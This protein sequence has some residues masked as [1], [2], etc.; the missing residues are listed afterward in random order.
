M[1]TNTSTVVE[2]KNDLPEKV[3]EYIKQIEALKEKYKGLV[4]TDVNDKEQLKLIKAGRIEFKNARVGVEKYCKGVRD[5]ANAFSKTVIQKEKEIVA[6][7]QPEEERLEAEE[8]KY[9]AEQQR[10]AEIK[11]KAEEELFNGRIKELYNLGFTVSEKGYGLYG[12][13]ITPTEI[14][15]MEP[16]AWQKVMDGEVKAA[17]ELDQADKARIARE[18]QERK[19]ADEKQ[20]Q[21]E[22]AK[23]KE[24]A[25]RLEKQRLEQ[26]EERKRLEAERDEQARKSNE[27]IQ[28]ERELQRLEQERLDAEKRKEEAIALEKQQEQLK[29]QAI[30]EER[31]R[32]EKEAKN[33]EAAEAL[34]REQE[35][36]KEER[37]PDKKKLIEFANSIAVLE[38]PEVKQPMMKT[39]ATGIKV[40][41]KELSDLIKKEVG[42]L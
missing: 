28:K 18:E 42:E 14:R 21:E 16:E 35:R 19:E 33:K 25:E 31:Q 1:E 27:L 10:M 24:E 20:R 11:R 39:Y 38:V 30:E 23:R 12:C 13:Y 15:L 41:L 9:E 36:I 32:I 8:A 5:G 34:K 3:P 4:L 17:Y 40:K 2:F 29:K 6:L 26:E 7:I 22:E 37:K